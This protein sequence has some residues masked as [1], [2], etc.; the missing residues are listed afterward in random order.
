MKRI[1]QKIKSQNNEQGMALVVVLL[2]IVVIGVMGTSLMSLAASNMKMSSGERN[3]Q[4]A[5]YIAE[6][7]VTYKMNQINTKVLSIYSTYNTPGE[8]FSKFETEMAVG[9]ASQAYNNFD[10]SF[11]QN[12]IANIKVESINTSSATSKDYKITSVGTIDNRSRTVEK[13]FNLTWKPK[14]IVDFPTDHAVFVKSTMNMSGS[15]F[16]KGSI[17]TASSQ[18]GAINLYDSA[19]ISDVVGT[20]SISPNDVIKINSDKVKIGSKETIS[21]TTNF[22][23]PTWDFPDDTISSTNYTATNNKTLSMITNLSYNSFKLTDQAKVTINLNGANRYLVVNDFEVAD[24]ASIDIE[25]GKLTI[26]VMRNFKYSS[27]NDINKNS[28][29]ENLE[30]FVKASEP[31]QTIT[32]TGSG[33]IHGSLFAENANISITGNTGFQGHIITGGM[34]V[35]LSGNNQSTTRLFYAPNATVTMSTNAHIK[36]TLV[37]NNFISSDNAMVTFA[38]LSTESLPLLPGNGSGGVTSISEL[39]TNQDPVRE[40]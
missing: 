26:Y 13:T 39:I 25:G 23:M 37:A 14:S 24:N 33:K 5:Y 7:G 18:S 12:P 4:S 11:G 20:Y 8:F 17:G 32:A 35:D 40:R 15:T 34:K 2:V 38:E 21:T 29:V 28:N 16:I 22:L 6:S 19:T 31:A 9:G 3:S 10:N 36:G 1:L 27:N 30:F